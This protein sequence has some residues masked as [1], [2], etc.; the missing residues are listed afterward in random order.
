MSAAQKPYAYHL[1]PCGRQNQKKASSTIES[2][3]GS[4]ASAAFRRLWF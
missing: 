2:G 1:M 4:I 3:S